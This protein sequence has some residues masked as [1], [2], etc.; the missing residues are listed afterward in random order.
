MIGQPLSCGFSSARASLLKSRPATPDRIFPAAFRWYR[1]R[2]RTE[3]SQRI[4]AMRASLVVVCMCVSCTAARPA[5]SV[6][7]QATGAP[8]GAPNAPIAVSRTI[9]SPQG[10]ESVEEIFARARVDYA[11][12]RFDAAAHGFDRIVELDPD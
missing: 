10:A 2:F 3:P 6:V 11:E 5:P 9:V 8:A 7:P 12:R 1:A 4:S